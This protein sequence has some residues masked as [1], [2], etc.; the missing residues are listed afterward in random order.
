MIPILQGGGAQ[1]PRDELTLYNIDV[2]TLPKVLDDKANPA[3]FDEKTGRNAMYPKVHRSNPL[4]YR[5]QYST[6]DS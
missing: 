1:P 2:G 5:D 3:A 4:V 6:T